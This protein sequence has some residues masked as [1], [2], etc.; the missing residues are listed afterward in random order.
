MPAQPA[1]ADGGTAISALAPFGRD[2]EADDARE[3]GRA[4]IFARKTDGDTDR[5]QKSEIGEDGV[6]RRGN[7]REQGMDVRRPASG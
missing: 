6:A 5:E 3:A 1:S 7:E 2:Q 4:V